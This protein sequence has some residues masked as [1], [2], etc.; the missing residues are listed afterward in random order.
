[1]LPCLPAETW[2]STGLWSNLSFLGWGR[3]QICLMAFCV[4]V[5][6]VCCSKLRLFYL[7]K[8]AKVPILKNFRTL[9]CIV[10]CLASK[11]YMPTLVWYSA[12]VWVRMW[13]GRFAMTWQCIYWATA[14]RAPLKSPLKGKSTEEMQNASLI[15]FLMVNAPW[16]SLW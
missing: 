7:D 14:F 3:R 12:N 2:Q 9:S 6:L 13:F 15:Q 4:E 16:I 1:M 11:C 10:L 8:L 5:S